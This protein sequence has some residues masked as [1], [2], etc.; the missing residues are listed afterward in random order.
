MAGALAFSFGAVLLRCR[1]A[2]EGENVEN[3]SLSPLVEAVFFL[4]VKFFADLENWGFVF[5]FIF[6]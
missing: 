2:Q 6:S 1:S 4:E 5:S 3:C